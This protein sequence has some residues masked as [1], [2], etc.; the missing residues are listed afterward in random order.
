MPLTLL[1]NRLVVV[2]QDVGVM[3]DCWRALYPD[4][5]MWLAKE[6]SVRTS[7]DGEHG[8]KRKGKE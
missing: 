6:A 1:Y 2:S 7:S 8:Y 3:E 4:G 5:W